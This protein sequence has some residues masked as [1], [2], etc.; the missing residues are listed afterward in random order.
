MD[1]N[2]SCGHCGQ[3]A[4]LTCTGCKN[5]KYCTRPHQT[6]DWS[7][8]K[9]LCKSFADLEQRP[10]DRY[11]RA[12]LLPENKKKPCFVWIPTITENVSKEKCEE[13][14]EEKHDE[15]HEMFEEICEEASE[16]TIQESSTETAQTEATQEMG[17]EAARANVD[18]MSPF[19]EYIRCNSSDTESEWS[20]DNETDGDLYKLPPTKTIQTVTAPD[21]FTSCNFDDLQPNKC[22]AALTKADTSFSCRGPLVLYGVINI[23]MPY[24]AV[25][26]LDTTDLVVGIDHLNE[27]FGAV[28]K[29]IQM[30]EKQRGLCEGLQSIKE[31]QR[32]KGSAQPK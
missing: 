15:A 21:E 2:N 13:F 9:L 24:E 27:R 29:R 7:T 4:S 12:I 28:H 10:D 6:A 25:V 14:T 8:H 23:G 26:D 20:S 30:T 22:V 31:E 16:H 3:P 1:I 18:D 11:R 17:W 5:I 32:R 19:D